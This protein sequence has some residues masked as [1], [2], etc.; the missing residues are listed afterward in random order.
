MDGLIEGSARLASV[1]VKI[2]NPTEGGLGRAEIGVKFERAVE[3]SARGCGVVAGGEIDGAEF[4]VKEGQGRIAVNR[5]FKARNRLLKHIRIVTQPKIL[6]E[7]PA[8]QSLGKCAAER[9]GG[10][11]PVFRIADRGKCFVHEAIVAAVCG[12]GSEGRGV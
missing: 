8:D 2:G 12:I 9:I 11:E 5:R 7:G 10:V 4:V 6:P 1:A 3:F